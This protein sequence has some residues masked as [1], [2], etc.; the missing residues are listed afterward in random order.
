MNALDGREDHLITRTA[1][2]IGK[3]LG[4][5]EG[6]AR[7]KVE[8]YTVLDQRENVQPVDVCLNC[9]KVTMQC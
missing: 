4:L 3:E 1:A 2:E 6:R 8:V 9:C 7:I 5:A